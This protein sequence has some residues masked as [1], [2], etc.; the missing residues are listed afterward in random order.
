MEKREEGR[1]EGRGKHHAI[2]RTA[3][4]LSPPS[5][6]SPLTCQLSLLCLTHSLKALKASLYLSSCI[7]RAAMLFQASP[8]VGSCEVTRTNACSMRGG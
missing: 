7:H 5:V 6:S 1:E 4:S 2:D 3:E 8:C